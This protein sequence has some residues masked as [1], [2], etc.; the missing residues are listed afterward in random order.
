MQLLIRMTIGA[1]AVHPQSTPLGLAFAFA[2]SIAAGSPEPP[3]PAHI[4]AAPRQH[5]W[6]PRCPASNLIAPLPAIPAV[7][8]QRMRVA[9]PIS[10]SAFTPSVRKAAHV[11]GQTLICVG[12]PAALRT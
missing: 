6:S 12:V 1:G 8:A 9:Q 7:N 2:G 10:S 11:L 4:I 5:T 3:P